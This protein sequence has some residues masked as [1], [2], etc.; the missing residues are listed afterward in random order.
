[1]K[2]LMSLAAVFLICFGTRAQDAK[3]AELA[4]QAAQKTADATIKG[5][6]AA[7]IDNTYPKVVEMMGGRDAAI[8]TT[9]QLMK[10]LAGQGMTIKSY[11]VS[12][13]GEVLSEGGNTF[14]VIPAVMEMKFAKG[15]VRVKS[16][17]LAISTDTG[18]TWKLIDG[19]GLADKN[20]REQLLPKL[21][22]ALKLPENQQPEIIEDK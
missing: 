21:P 18:K 2:H 19:N 12:D 13:P 7:L 9:T 4:K 10:Q 5:D 20:A 3:P 14:S 8:A 22:A 1:M 16:Y 15:I 6:Y 11:T 17:L